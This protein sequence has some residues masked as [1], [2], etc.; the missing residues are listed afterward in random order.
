MGVGWRLNRDIYLFICCPSTICTLFLKQIY[1]QFL[2]CLRIPSSAKT[3]QAYF[4]E[5]LISPKHLW[6]W[7]LCLPPFLTKSIYTSWWKCTMTKMKTSSYT[8]ALR[9]KVYT[10]K[11]QLERLQVGSNKK[12]ETNNIIFFIKYFY[13]ISLWS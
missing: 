13:F 5:C 6:N 2:K 8:Q 1:A 3:I 11:L 4:W 9:I 7:S 12:L 10:H